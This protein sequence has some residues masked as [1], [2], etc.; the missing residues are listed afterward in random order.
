[1]NEETHTEP[2]S[3][4]LPVYATVWKSGLDSYLRGASDQ[5]K[6]YNE[7]IHNGISPQEYNSHHVYM[8]V[9][10]VTVKIPGK[11]ERIQTELLAIDAGLE[12]EKKRSKERFEEL[13]E[14]KKEL[15]ALPHLAS[16][17]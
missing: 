1:M 12:A 4:E 10:K 5:I 17:T 15:L 16:D 3:F 14:R 2:T 6:E 7:T 11:S 13:E 9:G 8:P